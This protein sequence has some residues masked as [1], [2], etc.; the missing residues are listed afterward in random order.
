M[1][2]K[3]G[4]ALLQFS[5]QADTNELQ[6]YN[7]QQHETWNCHKGNNTIQKSA[8]SETKHQARVYLWFSV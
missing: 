3:Y 2:W 7:L 8:K 1:N 4:I 5:P 6:N